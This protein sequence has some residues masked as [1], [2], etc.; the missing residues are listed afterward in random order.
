MV[1]TKNTTT[2]KDWVVVCCQYVSFVV[3]QLL[4]LILSSPMG[5]STPSFLILHYS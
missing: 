3:A 5:C 2:S 4:S 1:L